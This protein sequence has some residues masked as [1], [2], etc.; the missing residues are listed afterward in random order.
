MRTC[1]GCGKDRAYPDTKVDTIHLCD[2]C[3]DRVVDRAGGL[4]PGS[5][6][7]IGALYA[8]AGVPHAGPVPRK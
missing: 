5:I 3:F 2:S 7:E 8:R 1:P 6:A 4:H